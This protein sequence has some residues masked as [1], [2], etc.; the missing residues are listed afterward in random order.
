MLIPSRS[1][2]GVVSSV[3]VVVTWD[4]LLFR[5]GMLVENPVFKER[6][7][8]PCKSKEAAVQMDDIAESDLALGSR[9]GK[10]NNV[11]TA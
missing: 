8:N 10:G 7:E 1:F 9:C 2:T 11:C 6:K 4:T 3:V 5:G